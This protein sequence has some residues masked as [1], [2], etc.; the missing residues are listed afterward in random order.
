ML[1]CTVKH[2]SLPLGGPVDPKL[3][4]PRAAQQKSRASPTLQLGRAG[5]RL[6]AV[7]PYLR[8]GLRY[9]RLRL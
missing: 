1:T 3:T 7:A 9:A 8:F 5:L 4:D 6:R 2:H